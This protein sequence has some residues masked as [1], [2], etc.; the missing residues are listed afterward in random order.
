MGLFQKTVEAAGET[1][2]YHTLGIIIPDTIDKDLHVIQVVGGYEPA[3][4]F[5]QKEVDT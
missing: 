5:A 1:D 3:R 2:C 4:A